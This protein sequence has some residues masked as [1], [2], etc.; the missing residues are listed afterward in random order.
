MVKSKITSKFANIIKKDLE[1][2]TA[3]NIDQISEISLFGSCSRGEYRYN[4]DVDL[5]IIT[6]GNKLDRS[7]TGFIRGELEYIDDTN[8]ATD[9]VF[10]DRDV[11]D[12]SKELIVNNIKRDKIVLWREGD[13]TDEYKELL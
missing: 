5:I 7:I 3:L 4:S 6:K 9:I 10:Y 2:I 12:S 8:V 13:Y 11:F 1:F